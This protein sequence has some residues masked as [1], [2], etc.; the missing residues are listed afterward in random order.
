MGKKM[1]APEMFAALTVREADVLRSVLR[2]GADVAA[3]VSTANH[4]MSMET[5]G[6]MGD[7]GEARRE[8]WNRENPGFEIES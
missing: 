7:I 2:S 4:D 8:R 5:Y 6:V 1:P 3:H